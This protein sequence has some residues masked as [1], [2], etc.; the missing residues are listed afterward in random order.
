MRSMQEVQLER[1][2]IDMEIGAILVSL[3]KLKTRRSE[4]ELEVLQIQQQMITEAVKKQKEGTSDNG[5]K[6]DKN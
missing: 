6:V 2:K 5:P 3:N 4:L 1:H